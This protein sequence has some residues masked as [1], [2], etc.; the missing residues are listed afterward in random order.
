MG[1]VNTAVGGGHNQI[2]T[3]TG[4]LQQN[5]NPVNKGCNVYAEGV[6]IQSISTPV[7]GYNVLPNTYAKTIAG[8][9][10]LA[11]AYKQI[12]LRYYIYQKGMDEYLPGVPVYL[13]VCKLTI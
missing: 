3:K 4:L 7:Q 8:P 11:I 1:F 5:P 10:V 9:Q 13:L 6:L 2:I 12:K